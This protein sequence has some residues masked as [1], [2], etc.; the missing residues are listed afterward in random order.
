MS[1]QTI[2][3]PN[4]SYEFKLTEAIS[5]PIVER[6]RKQ[7]E[8]DARKKGEEP[9]RREQALSEKTAEIERAQ[10]AIDA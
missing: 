1:D 6:P 5:A 10:E 3:C 2:A 7:F 4:C 9:I 8:A